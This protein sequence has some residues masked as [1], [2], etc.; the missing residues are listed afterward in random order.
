MIEWS[1]ELS[2]YEIHYEPRGTIRAQSLVDCVN[3]FHPQP[4]FQEYW[5]T[6]H[7]DGS[8]IQHGSKA[9]VILE[10]P[11]SV[12]VLQS[13]LSLLRPRAIKPNKKHY[14]LASS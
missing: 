5:W 14:F 13:L 10:W 4:Q 7:V 2:E 3:N 1:I 12:T 6:L 11:N 8:S 9:G